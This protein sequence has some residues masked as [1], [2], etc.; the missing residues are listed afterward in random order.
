[1]A[2]HGP[3]F[4]WPDRRNEPRR[5]GSLGAVRHRARSAKGSNRRF[6]PAK[7]SSASN[8]MESAPSPAWAPALA[9]ASLRW[10]PASGTTTSPANQHEALAASGS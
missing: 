1:M 10:P 7:A 6:G 8:A 5:Y 2:A 3:R 4:L 9:Y